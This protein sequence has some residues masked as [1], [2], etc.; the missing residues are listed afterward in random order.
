MSTDIFRQVESEY[1]RLRDQLVAG[2][3]T[4]AQFDASLREMMVRDTAGRFWLLSSETGKW[5]VSHRGGWLQSDPSLLPLAERL[6]SQQVTQ[7]AQVTSQPV[8]QAA[9]PSTSNCVLLSCILILALLVTLVCGA[10]FFLIYDRE[11]SLIAQQDGP[12]TPLLATATQ[13]A[14]LRT[15]T[16]QRTV[17]LAQVTPSQP[18][19]TTTRTPTRLPTFVPPSQ[20]TFKFDNGIDSEEQQLIRDGIAFSAQ[21][22]GSAGPVT[23]YAYSDLNRL[24]ES[25]AS[26]LQIPSNDVRVAE[27]K[28]DFEDVMVGRGGSGGIW[29]WV[30]ARWKDKSVTSRW[31]TL[32][33]EYFHNVQSHLSKKNGI[34]SVP[35]WLV[36]GSAEY[37]S[38]TSI[39]NLGMVDRSLQFREES[40]RARSLS[41]P[42]NTMETGEGARAEDISAFYSLGTIA[43]DYL[44]ARYGGYDPVATNFWTLKATRNWQEAFQGAFGVTPAAFYQSFETFR[45]TN[46]TPFCGKQSATS[47]VPFGMQ[48]DRQH[49]PGGV[50]LADAAWTL[51]P[52][53]PY[54]FCMIGV[55]PQDALLMGG[56]RVPSGSVGWASC[57]ASCFVVYMKPSAPPGQ[58]LVELQML[59][60]RTIRATFPHTVVAATATPFR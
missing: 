29:I 10:L 51:P 22:L 30:S 56:I 42:L 54:T 31:R 12:A 46:L 44:A 34:E 5:L 25:Y 53:I 26:F 59:D 27:M 48:F 52:N 40:M 49:A 7:T 50:I 58:Y 41:N 36:E 28:R 37:A 33:H 47:T 23:I 16:A 18:P 35:D 32:A 21:M 4:R 14:P 1:M 17:T 55:T 39:S 9:R 43:V 57:G 20:V 60:A 2:F 6:G 15:P 19:S 11:G 45:K 13:S 8:H 24:A 38:I 3:I